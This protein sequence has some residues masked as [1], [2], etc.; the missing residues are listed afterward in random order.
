MK[1]IIYSASVFYL[2]GLKLT[3]HVEIKS[4]LIHKT[5]IFAPPIDRNKENAVPSKDFRTN[6]A[7]KDSTIS[8]EIKKGQL[9]APCSKNTKKDSTPSV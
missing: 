7:S 8:T 5:E 1:L 6:S 3:S 9:I 2:L 4:N